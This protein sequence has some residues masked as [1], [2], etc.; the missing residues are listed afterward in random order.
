MDPSLE[1]G[2]LELGDG[3]EGAVLQV[4]VKID[5]VVGPGDQVVAPQH[6]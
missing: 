3:N 1:L 2:D 6:G 4:V 5:V